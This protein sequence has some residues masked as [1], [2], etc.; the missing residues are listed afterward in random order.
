MSGGHFDYSEYAML[1]I[2]DQIELL[3]Q[4]NNRRDLNH[5]GEPIGRDYP[6]EIIAHLNDAIAA[7]RRAYVYAHRIDYLVS[8]DDGEKEFIERLIEELEAL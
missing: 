5:Y 6:P 2:A 4:N 3:V 1:R 8:G 7:L